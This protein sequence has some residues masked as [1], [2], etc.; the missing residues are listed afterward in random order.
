MQ[1]TIFALAGC[2][3]AGVAHARDPLV[4]PPA[5]AVPAGVSA[6]ETAQAIK[7]ALV[8]RTWVVTKHEPAGDGG[9]ID[10]A[11]NIRAH[12]ATITIAYDA[13][14]IDLDYVGSVNLDYKVKRN[15]TVL[16]HENYNGWINYLVADIQR[17]L[18]AATV[19]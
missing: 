4:D 2:L 8:G 10:A 7:N 15:G 11:L 14:E 13:R 6:E 19:D 12:Q 3:V 18:Q 16:I 1:R 17:H 9:R 5:I